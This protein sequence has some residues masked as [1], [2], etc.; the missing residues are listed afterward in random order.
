MKGIIA[1]GNN[2]TLY[3]FIKRDCYD[4]FKTWEAVT[5]Y[6]PIFSDFVSNGDIDGYVKTMEALMEEV[7]SYGVEFNGRTAG[8]IKSSDQE[9]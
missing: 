6:E 8:D 9:S 4:G 3:S 5:K 2:G 1:I 7:K